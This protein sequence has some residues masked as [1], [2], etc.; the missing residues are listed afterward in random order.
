MPWTASSTS[1]PRLPNTSKVGGPQSSPI[2]LSCALLTHT[3]G[4]GEASTHAADIPPEATPSDHAPASFAPSRSSTA[5]ARYRKRI[6]SALRLHARRTSTS[7][8]HLRHACSG[9][10][11]GQL[12]RGEN[13]AFLERFRYM[14]IASDLL[15]EHHQIYLK[16]GEPSGPTSLDADH[17]VKPVFSTHGVFGIAA[18][19]FVLAAAIAWARTVSGPSS[20]AHI[21][22]LILLLG[23]GGVAA[24]S[25]A[26]RK[27]LQH[28]RAQ[29]ADAT[30]SFM[31]NAKALDAAL[32]T[33][34]TI[35]QEVEL[36]ARGYRIST[37][38]PPASRLDDQGQQRRCSR[39]RK[40]AGTAIQQL[41]QPTAR[42]AM[43]LEQWTVRDDLERYHDI[44]EITRT[45]LEDVTL[46]CHGSTVEGEEGETL[47]ALKVGLQQLFM[48]RKVLLCSL[49]ALDADGTQADFSRWTIVAQSLQDLSSKYARSAVTLDALLSDQERFGVPTNPKAPLTPSR[50]KTRTQ[51]RKLGGLSTGIR[52][53]QAKMHMLREE[54]D[55]H[56]DNTE[57]SSD[58]S[59]H[60]MSQYEAIGADLKAL[61]HEWEE[62]KA[63]LSQSNHKRQSI[64]SAGLLSPRAETPTSWSGTTAIGESPADALKALNGE[65]MSPR[66]DATSSDEEIFEAIAIPRQR[67]TFTREERI[68]KMRE[69]RDQREKA[70]ESR[71]A[72]TNML[73]ELETVL[74]HKPQNNK[75]ARRVTVM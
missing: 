2:R 41:L 60:L 27:W 72:S 8:S 9:V 62:G 17:T 45:Y 34:V 47:R 20:L 49:L 12:G 26:R 74:K 1:T 54:A 43:A 40:T 70:R 66:L 68:V 35:V 59:A 55:Q 52:S 57:D 22:L 58:L 37:P 13:A 10:V 75:A 29:A 7:L 19:A 56:L 6:P 48:A 18:A 61:L 15:N 64:S 32:S 53:L 21:T 42:A 69:D 50:E 4:R 3:P 63:V 71:M 33:A 38:L 23:L 24:Y 36:V 39:F 67:S 16:Q 46:S 28:I 5:Y 51:I 44:Y 25:F 31:S 11:K 30:R 73:R 65:A 14:I